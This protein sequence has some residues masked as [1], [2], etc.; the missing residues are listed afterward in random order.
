MLKCTSRG[1]G[2]GSWMGPG[3]RLGVVRGED[4]TFSGFQSVEQFSN[5][6]L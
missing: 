4:R 3:G 6:N 1:W 5:I 2:M